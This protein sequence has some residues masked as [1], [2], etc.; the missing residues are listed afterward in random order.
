MTSFATLEEMTLPG[1]PNTPNWAGVRHHF[2]IQSFGVNA[3]TSTEGGQ[4]VIGEHDE[5][6]GG[7]AGHEELY[8]VMSGRATFTVEAE[9]FDAPAGTVVFV[10]DP[11]AKRG[12]VAVDAETTILAFGARAGEAF[13][14]S[15]WELSAPAFGYF[16]TGEYEKAYEMLVKTN[17]EHPDVPGVLYN[18]A[19][20]E[21]RTGRTEEAISHLRRALELGERYREPAKT[22]PDFDPIKDEPAFRELVG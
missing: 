1:L 18:L 6:T 5:L 16:G 11:A 12:A 19:C 17:E 13:S 4:A 7:A 14:P 21:S 22:D 20:S 8:I 3:W 2:G 10:R 9:E 15:Q